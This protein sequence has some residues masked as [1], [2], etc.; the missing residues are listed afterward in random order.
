[1]TKVDD[2]LLQLRG[3][4][5]VRA[6]LEERGATPPEL[7]QHTAEIERVRTELARLAVAETVQAA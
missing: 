3:L 4:V 5:H 7:D 1:M 2:L 6:I